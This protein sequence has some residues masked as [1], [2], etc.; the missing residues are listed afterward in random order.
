[1][2]KLQVVYINLLFLCIRQ[3]V[4]QMWRLVVGCVLP[5]DAEA[6]DV[7]VH[8]RGYGIGRG[9]VGGEDVQVGCIACIPEDDFFTPVTEEVG[10]QAWCGL[11]PVARGGV[12]QVVEVISEK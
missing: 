5:T 4:A 1:M 2:K 12:S 6:V 3:V 11:G 10:L 7:V 8:Q 9:D